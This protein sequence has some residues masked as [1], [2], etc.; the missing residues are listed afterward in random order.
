MLYSNLIHTNNLAQFN[1]LMA[2]LI[3]G[4]P[5]RSVF[6]KWEMDLL[7]DFG[8]CRI[9]KTAR[10]EI[11]KRYQRLVQTHMLRGE[12]SFAPF[13]VFLAAERARRN[14]IRVIAPAELVRAESSFDDLTC[15][16]CDND[17]LTSMAVPPAALSLS[18]GLEE[19]HA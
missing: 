1:I 19:L 18:S 5:N 10:P 7:L 16:S 4:G 9:R 11:L 13:S 12:Y 14:R 2:E 3:Q 6:Q 15:E 8:A 17:S